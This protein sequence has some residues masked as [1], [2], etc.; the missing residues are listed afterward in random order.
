MNETDGDYG[1]VTAK[2][3]DPTQKMPWRLTRRV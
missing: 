3:L 2:G 1:E